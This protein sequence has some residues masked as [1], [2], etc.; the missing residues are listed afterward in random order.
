MHEKVIQKQVSINSFYIHYC[1]LKLR[2][3]KPW[4][5]GKKINQKHYRN[6][7][8]IMPINVSFLWTKPVLVFFLIFNFSVLELGNEEGKGWARVFFFTTTRGKNPLLTTSHIACSTHTQKKSFF[9]F[10]GCNFFSSSG[11]LGRLLLR[12]PPSPTIV[13]LS[14]SL[15]LSWRNPNVEKE[16]GGERKASSF[17][18]A[19]RWEGGEEILLNYWIR[20]TAIPLYMYSTWGQHKSVHCCTNADSALKIK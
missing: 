4:A 2:C 20:P 19:Q 9:L 11:G 15:S 1:D 6:K 13:T 10:R 3:D 12:K 18:S 5:G 14:L 16:G 17:F 7:Q 8:F